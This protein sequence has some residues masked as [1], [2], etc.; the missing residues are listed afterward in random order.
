M[1]AENLCKQELVGRATRRAQSEEDR[2]TDEGDK[3][4]K[5]GKEAKKGTSPCFSLGRL[6]GRM[7]GVQK[8]LCTE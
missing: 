5:E 6:K 3:M 7:G 1:S 8:L 2:M 4:Q